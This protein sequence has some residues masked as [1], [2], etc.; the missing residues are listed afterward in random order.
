MLN[1]KHHQACIGVSI[2]KRDRAVII[3]WCNPLSASSK[4]N[5]FK[6]SYNT[7]VI[8]SQHRAGSSNILTVDEWELV[9]WCLT[10]LS[11]QTGYYRVTKKAKFTILHWESIGGCSS[12]SP[13][14]WAHRWRTTNVCDMW[15]VRRQTYGYLSSCKA[16]LP[17]GW[18]QIILLIDRGTRVL[19][20]PGLHSTAG[21]L[22]FKP[23]TCWSQVRHPTAMPPSHIRCKYGVLKFGDAGTLP[24]RIKTDNSVTR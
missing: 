21:R 7:A 1:T 19:T 22:G 13:R 10:P 11:A 15:P 17:I 23:A 12:P 14:P 18:Y 2:S 16:S 4:C 20:C 24:L 6:F 3:S 9:Y 5:C 8:W